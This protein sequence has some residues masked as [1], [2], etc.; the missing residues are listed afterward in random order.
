MGTRNALSWS[1]RAVPDPAPWRCVECAGSDRPAHRQVRV[2][3]Y[4]GTGGDVSS[5]CVLLAEQKLP[6]LLCCPAGTAAG[7]ACSALGCV[8]LSVGS[9]CA[10]PTCCSN[11]STHL[12]GLSAEQFVAWVTPPESLLVDTPEE[13]VSSEDTAYPVLSGGSYPAVG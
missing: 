7:R 8:G 11:T 13:H 4:G 5:P 1:L 9:L 6:C 3:K 10:R 2:C 12:P